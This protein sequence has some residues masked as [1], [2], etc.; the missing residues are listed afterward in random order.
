MTLDLKTVWLLGWLAVWTYEDIKNRLLNGWQI[1]A[2]IICGVLWQ[3]YGHC[4]FTWSTAGGILT[5]AAAWG[6]SLLTH[7]ALGRGDALVFACLGLYM[8]VESCISILLIAL[9]YSAVAS[10][11]LLVLKKKSRR[12]ELPFIPFVL[13]GYVTGLILL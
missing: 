7:G 11:Y 1:L 13:T 8:G 3:L 9:V 10:L 12:Y 4:L 5:G 6:V 2:V